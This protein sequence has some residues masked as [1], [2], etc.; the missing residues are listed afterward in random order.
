[1][2]S[3]YF[4]FYYSPAQDNQEVTLVEQAHVL[5]RFEW[6]FGLTLN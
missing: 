3:C 2:I 1:M 5:S 6:I 4:S